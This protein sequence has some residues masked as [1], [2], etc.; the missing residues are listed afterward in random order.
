MARLAKRFRNQPYAVTVGGKKMIG[1]SRPAA[2]S[3]APRLFSSEK[4]PHVY[5]GWTY[6]NR[7]R[8]TDRQ[9]S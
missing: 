7:H 2:T 8:R 5:G 6:G 1:A 3:Y 9:L 4:P